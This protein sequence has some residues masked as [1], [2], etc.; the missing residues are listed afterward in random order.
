MTDPGPLSGYI[1]QHIELRRSLG[2]ILKG[3]E[4]A[5]IEFDRY[6]AGTFPEVKTV[7]RSM[8]TG[9]L[10]SLSGREMMTLR[11]RLTHLRQFCRFMFQLDPETYIPERSLVPHASITRL[12]HIYTDEEATKLIKA[13]LAL[14]PLDSLRPHTYATILALLWVSGIRIS[15]ALRLNLEDIDSERA[16]LYIRQSKFFK[17]RLVPLAPSSISALEEYRMRRTGYGHDEGP[18][19]PF[20]VNLRGRR[21]NYYTVRPTFLVLSRQL[22]LKTIQGRDPRLHDFRHTF[23]TSYLSRVYETG[24]NPG[25]ALPLLATYLG[26][27]NITNTQT[28]LHPDISLLEKSGQRFHDYARRN[29]HEGI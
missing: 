20:F 15:E 12:A 16:V 25:A 1:A 17:S 7:T 9:Y 27:A 11:D 19:A 18:Q 24:K 3:A 6:L 22:G 2:F 13:A 14:P 8:V 23:A 4:Y 5:L 26:H 10:Q 21:C 28:Y 29:A